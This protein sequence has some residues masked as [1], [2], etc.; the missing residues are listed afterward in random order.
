M[1]NPNPNPANNPVNNLPNQPNPPHN[2]LPQQLTVAVRATLARMAVVL[3]CG[4]LD[5]ISTV[6][7][8]WTGGNSYDANVVAPAANGCYRPI[9][10]DK[11]RK[12]DDKCVQPLPS[13]PH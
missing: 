3:R 12:V 6:D 5:T 8:A 10:P 7:I 11:S 13:K 1:S 9:D 2:P 4:G